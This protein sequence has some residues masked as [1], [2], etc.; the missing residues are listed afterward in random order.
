MT[1]V[2]WSSG[3][4]F[5]FTFTGVTDIN[6]Q[7]LYISLGNPNAGQPMTWV[8][9][10]QIFQNVVYDNAA[11]TVTC[12]LP[13]PNNGYTPEWGQ[14]TIGY[15]FI[16]NSVENVL[17]AAPALVEFP[18]ENIDLMRKKIMA[19]PSVSTNAFAIGHGVNNL[20][21]WGTSLGSIDI[22]DVKHYYTEAVQEGLGVKTY[23]ADI[24]NTWMNK[25]WIDGDNGVNALSSVLVVDDEFTMDALNI[26]QKVYTMLNNIALSGGTF[27][28][29]VETVYDEQA[30]NLPNIPIYLGGLSK[31]LTFD[32]VISTVQTADQP[33][34]TLAGRGTMTSKHKGG[35]IYYKCKAYRDWEKIGR[36]HV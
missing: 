29:W 6:V 4:S 18:L 5:I 31:E 10:N 27:D 2:W 17:S 25:E 8:Q 24:F 33:L 15:Y 23:Q 20:A 34:G 36:A 26:A 13:R 35:H 32:A 1:L 19:Q 11:E 21:P 7:D 16:Q 12:T 30:V 14:A 3:S 22:D 28:N 9:A